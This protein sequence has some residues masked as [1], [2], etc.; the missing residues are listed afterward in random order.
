MCR[1]E[2]LVAIPLPYLGMRYGTLQPL[3]VK[4]VPYLPYLPYLFHRPRVHVCT[5]TR[6]YLRVRAAVNISME[7]MEGMEE[8]GAARVSGFHTLPSRSGRYGTLTKTTHRW[9]GLPWMR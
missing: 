6:V 9:E 5:R 1:S 7:G 2:G 8:Q 4:G 3:R